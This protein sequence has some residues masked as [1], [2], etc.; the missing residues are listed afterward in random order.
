MQRLSA[1][2]LQRGTLT[3]VQRRR[4]AVLFNACKVCRT[5]QRPRLKSTVVAA[6]VLLVVALGVFF[7]WT[8][9]KPRATLEAR[10]LQAPGDMVDVAGVRL[11]V[12]DSGPKDASAVILLHGFGASLHTWEAWAQDLAKDHRVIRFDL[13]GSGLSSPDPTGIYTDARSMQLLVALMDQRGVARAAIV[14]NSIGGRLAWTFAATHPERVSKLV[15][16]SPDGFASPGFDYGKV[17]EV[18]P[19]L[20]LMRYVLPKA[21]LRMSLAPAY[22][23]P[24][25]MTDDLATRYHD[26]MLAPGAR[27][28]LMA[29]MAQT[30]LVDPVP[31]L[32]RIEAPT[33]LLWGQQDA[34]IP[35]GNSADYLKAI[36]GARLVPVPGVG[37]LPQEEAPA[38]SLVSLREFLDAR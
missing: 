9:D 31:L 38:R 36:R 26:L 16:V 28:A 15:L 19:M 23:D 32:Q 3:L 22:A 2:M 17:P 33:L 27:D 6:V 12:R 29:R 1:S 25:V 30:T 24:Q 21:L 7:L 35:F 4:D 8:P 20:K 11:H 5:P 34:M 13:P 18:S 37:H 14:G 10:Y